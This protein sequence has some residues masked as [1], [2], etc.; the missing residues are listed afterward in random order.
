VTFLTFLTFLPEEAPMNEN[1]LKRYIVQQL[2]SPPGFVFPVETA[3]GGTAGCPDLFVLVQSA[4]L[5]L[6][7][8]V[9]LA[10]VTG[11][12]LYPRH[13]RSVQIA[14]HDAFA[15]AGGR[16]RF[17]FGVPLYGGWR[18]WVLDD[19]SRESLRV[20]RFQLVSLTLCTRALA[21]DHDVWWRGLADVVRAPDQKK[22]EIARGQGKPHVDQEG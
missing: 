18:I 19:C 21:F 7:V 5:L 10:E 16:A 12:W 3:R 8:E 13:I 22:H 20:Q 17:V 14:W 2:S 4:K 9:K 6:P 15:R 11:D 1:A